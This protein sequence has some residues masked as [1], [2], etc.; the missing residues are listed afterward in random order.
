MI[1]YG[2]LS[3]CREATLPVGG[4]GL[5]RMA[6]DLARGLRDLGHAVTLYAGPGSQAPEGVTLVEDADETARAEAMAST[7]WPD[8]TVMVDLSH[9]HDLSKLLPNWPVLN[10]LV[11]GEVT[12]EPPNILVGN[13]WQASYVKSS[14]IA[15]LGIDVAVHPFVEKPDDYVLYAGKLHPAKG[16]DIAIDVAREAGAR[17]VMLGSNLVGAQ[18]P[19]GV[20]YLGPVADER[21]FLSWVCHAKALL[22]PSR[23]DAGGRVLLNAAACGTPSLVFDQ[24]GCAGHVA[25]GVSGFVCRDGAEMVEALRDVHL[26][27]RAGARAWCAAEHSL[28]AM[29]STVALYGLAVSKGSRW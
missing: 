18:P 3:D 15:P 14:R 16:F 22:S 25:H 8:A 6:F 9:F 29:A 19:E 12:F 5:G 1:K 24:T 20:T 7:N 23:F 27:D 21:E 26:I 10:W 17:L 11:D 28:E 2:V 13:K 4:H